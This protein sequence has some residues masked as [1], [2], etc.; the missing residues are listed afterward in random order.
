[1]RTL[2][3]FA[4]TLAL[5]CRAPSEGVDAD[6]P[7]ADSDS[8]PDTPVDTPTDT[9]DTD[10][11]RASTLEASGPIACDDPTERADVGR[12]QRR[13]YDVPAPPTPHLEGANASYG[14]LN[15]DG[16]IDIVVTT[17]AAVMVWFRSP[18]VPLPDTTPVVVHADPSGT[19]VT[20][21]FGATVVDVDDDGDLDLM[22]TGR[23]VANRLLHNDGQGAFTDATAAAGLD[24]MP[25][26]HTTGASFADMDGDGDLD[27]FLAGHGFVDETLESPTLFQPAD[28]SYLFENTG[29]GHFVDVSHLLPATAQRGYTFLGGWFDADGDGDD[30]L[31][32]LN[33]FGG[34]VVPCQLLLNELREGGA[35]RADDNAAGADAA[36]AGMGLGIGDYDRDG[37]EDLALVAWKRNHFYMHQGP[38]FFESASAMGFQPEL[39]QAVGWGV[40]MADI[41]NDGL[42]D[43]GAT[44]GYLETRFGGDNTRGQPDAFWVQQADGT[45]R[46]LAR[47]GALDDPQP[48]RVMALADYNQ[49]GW[50]DLVRVGLDGVVR[51]DLSRCGEEAWVTVQLHQP[52]PNTGAVGATVRVTAQGVTQLRRVRAGGTGYGNGQPLELHFGLGD[53]AQIDA[54]EVTWPDGAV[55]SWTDL[56]PRQRLQ[57]RR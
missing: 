18:G 55:E 46:D 1:V 12:F 42:L 20:G 57:I 27:L 37:D 16:L 44:Y 11:P 2:T 17:H 29:G 8:A 48:H 3:A 49:D 53:A 50:L 52:A 13:T 54:L 43:L 9:P 38:L 23:G 15:G 45:V 21:L 32:L 5:A 35:F 41:D 6:T 25:A 56:T 31:Y 26:H 10:P 7:P 22:V 14:D 34:A 40:E 47:L 51:F 30:D 36:F 4:L 39:P 24:P 28:P 19:A 33:D